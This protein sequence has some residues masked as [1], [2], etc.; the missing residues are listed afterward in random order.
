MKK[1]VSIFLGA[2]ILLTLVT[3]F[4]ISMQSKKTYAG[5]SDA[6]VHC[7]CCGHATVANAHNFGH[8]C[9]DNTVW[10]P[11]GTADE[12]LALATSSDVH[13]YLT[14]DIEL[15]S[16][17]EVPEAKLYICLNGHNITST[18]RVFF[19]EGTA[20]AC[21]N[22]R[23]YITDCQ[24]TPGTVSGSSK[25]NGG[26]LH[27]AAGRVYTYNGIFTSTGRETT[28]ATGG[29]FYFKGVSSSA[30]SWFYMLGGTIKDGVAVTGGNITFSSYAT[31]FFYDGEIMDG[32]ADTYGGNVNAGASVTVN[33]Y[34]T[35]IHGGT[36]STY[37]GNVVYS[38]TASM[39]GGK[40]YDGTASYG[41]NVDV[42]N[43]FT[44]T[45]GEIY[46]GTATDNYGGNVAIQADSTATMSAGKIYNGSAGTS[47]GNVAAYGGTF[48][49]SG[50]EIYGGTTG[51]TS[52]NKGGN[53]WISSYTSS[54]K[55]KLAKGTISGGKIHDGS[56]YRGGNVMGEGDADTLVTITGGEIYNGSASN[57]GGNMSFAACT[58]EFRG[59]SVYDG[60]RDGSKTYKTSNLYASSA[61][62]TYRF[63]GGEIAGH[64][65]FP[66]NCKDLTFGGSFKC[67]SGN[68]GVTIE[69]T[70]TDSKN[71]LIYFNKFNDD[72][73]ILIEKF[74][75][76]GNKNWV[77]S[78]DPTFLGT[79]E[80][81]FTASDLKHVN[82]NEGTITLESD[83]TLHI[84]ADRVG[85]IC[86]GNLE[87]GKTYGTGANAVTHHCT[88]VTWTKWTATD[89]LPTVATVGEVPGTYY[90]YLTKNVTLAS[91]WNPANTA[92][93]MVADFDGYHFVIDFNGHTVQMS[94]TSRFMTNLLSSVYAQN[95]H[96]SFTDSGNGGGVTM[97]KN[98]THTTNAGSLF[99]LNSKTAGYKVDIYG[100]IYNGNGGT[101]TTAKGMINVGVS[102]GVLNMFG[103]T[104]ICETT[105][106]TTSN[107]T[108]AGINVTSGTFNMYGGTI[109]DG[110]GHKGGN[111]YV[112]GSSSVFNM[113][114]GE[115]TNGTVS[116]ME[117]GYSGGNVYVASSGTFN[118]YGGKITDGSAYM[119]GNITTTAKLNI[120]DGEITGGLAQSNGANVSFY[121]GCVG[122]M[123]GGY[124][125][126]A[127][128]ENTKSNI[129]VNGEL[130][131]NGGKLISMQAISGAVTFNGG[132][133][134]G[135]LTT[136]A[137]A[138]SFTINGGYF[139]GSLS[140]TK[141]THTISGGIFVSDP[142]ATIAT[143]PDGLKAVDTNVTKDGV[144]YYFAIGEA[145]SIQVTST[146]TKEGGVL[147]TGDGYTLATLTAPADVVKNLPFTLTAPVVS[148]YKFSGW[149]TDPAGDPVSTAAT[150]EC[151]GV[152]GDT[153]FVAYYEAN[154]G[155]GYTLT[156]QTAS[157][158]DFTYSV[159]LGQNKVTEGYTFETGDKVGVG[160]E[161]T[162]THAACDNFIGWF[163]A[164]EKLVSADFEYKFRI[165]DDTLI[166]ARYT[167]STT[168]R[169]LML[170]DQNQVLADMNLSEMTTLKDLPVRIG[171]V[172]EGWAYN[173]KTYEA[174]ADGLNE[175]RTDLA[176]AGISEGIVQLKATYTYSE[177]LFTIR[178]Q[179]A[180]VEDG[181][182]MDGWKLSGTSE[183]LTE[184]ARPSQEFTV[185]TETKKI[186][187]YKFIGYTLV[188]A[189]TLISRNETLKFKPTKDTV[190]YAVYAANVG[191]T[192]PTINWSGLTVTEQTTAGRYTYSVTALR[193]VPAPFVM[194]EHGV[195]ITT[196]AMGIND[197]TEAMNVLTVDATGAV[198]SISKATDTTGTYTMNVKN[199]MTDATAY[200]R[201]YVIYLDNMGNRGVAYTDVA[202]GTGEGPIETTAPVD[203]F[204]DA[205]FNG[206]ILETPVGVTVT[207]LKGFVDSGT[208]SP[209]QATETV[210][211]NGKRRTYFEA[212][213]AGNYT[214]VAK[215]TG[216]Y[217][218]R[219]QLVM[220]AAEAAS[221]YVVDA[222]PGLRLGVP[223][224]A[225][226]VKR[227]N[228][229]V[230]NGFLSQ[231]TSR[232][233]DYQ[234]AFET[235][236]FQRDSY[237]Y[238]KNSTTT[239]AEML[240]F[241][242]SLEDGVHF[243][244]YSFGTSPVHNLDSQL[245]VLTTSDL[246][247]A[248]TYEEAA[249]IVRANGKLN[250]QIVTGMH[251]S[252][253][254]S[255]EAGLA[256]AKMLTTAA[257]E[258][259]L[260]KMNVIFVP[261]LNPDGS[262]EYTRENIANGF[263]MNRDQLSSVAVEVTDA[264]RVFR[265]FMAEAVLDLHEYTYTFTSTGNGVY[266]EV[267][268]GIG[269]VYSETD[270]RDYAWNATLAGFSE[271]YDNGISGKYYP[272]EGST[273]INGA[274]VRTGRGYYAEYGGISFLIESC[275]I[276]G[277]F[278]TYPMR[279]VGHCIMT[280]AIFDYFLEN[281]ELKTM[282]SDFRDDIIEN[283]GTYDPNRMIQLDTEPSGTAAGTHKAHQVNFSTGIY[284]G[285][286]SNISDYLLDKIL[287]ER[288]MPTA[289][290]MP[291][292]A[293]GIN[294]VLALM[295][296]HGIRY[297]ETTGA[298]TIALKQYKKLSA[299]SAELTAEKNVTFANGAYVFE[300]NQEGAHILAMLMEPDAENSGNSTLAM[301]GLVSADGDNLYPIY[302]YE[303]NLTDKTWN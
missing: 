53:I 109:R 130:T 14:A 269:N 93:S 68:Y 85:C 26:T 208:D 65:A 97:K 139:A 280:Q 29:V 233:P 252:E 5:G 21:D 119:G 158:S 296:K 84:S 66:Y 197:V 112:T 160:C 295:D 231:D 198:R 287:L 132:T 124:I 135:S 234:Y 239:H 172:A 150:Y 191:E 194:L 104:I 276:G 153:L 173:G 34:E 111:V 203:A 264:H 199:I 67:H 37:G 6:H 232:W 152:S 213:A 275:G 125:G 131:V 118:M 136:Y 2:V 223:G 180:T 218:A 3:V 13:A 270:M 79:A 142:A 178:L 31:A 211:K 141:G 9:N 230:E 87:D 168:V 100:G 145:V 244:T 154:E 277:D 7:L 15:T 147:K 44:M 52:S 289:Y 272:Y 255:A 242:H 271:L 78:S 144:T 159:L 209:I 274:K 216:Y 229:K 249:A 204:D 92:T 250:V 61:D 206:L 45:G 122:T 89:A 77:G 300:M 170:S 210:V 133:V 285:T 99:W 176:Q 268:S 42:R 25:S 186:S 62:G 33:H 261:R 8:K 91:S 293:A 167:D 161:I 38:G 20:S 102:D 291:K 23:L 298:A 149:Y 187:Q 292:D 88:D 43:T 253:P 58:L 106:D 177:E 46:N 49:M 74:D 279:V 120:Y 282:V 171:K 169:I 243:K 47:G 54:G 76:S 24:D 200:L 103:G 262:Y 69:N 247:A 224:E 60:K 107:S 128:A 157:P 117:S 214:Y 48:N 51:T 294:D 301:L 57:Q 63:T 35:A 189:G 28:D 80:E 278:T 215:G 41:G 260:D 166:Y 56:A 185:E 241:I 127:A 140:F 113:Y 237:E 184:E 126:A 73:D 251:G 202:Y 281:P 225:S 40:V 12:F 302:R 121:T 236:Y 188:E 90:F 196:S 98:A 195:L 108:N 175:L 86:G 96:V 219:T 266:T 165:G 70:S 212:L 226:S 39:S 146:G 290:V 248:D 30:K 217:T 162:L 138:C 179:K 228:E 258:K 227:Y 16:A 18:D 4:G 151:E 163:N 190:V 297:Y 207:L 137:D 205:D 134:T 94:T 36:A 123:D 11:I 238:G 55:M 116:V 81:G 72:A 245:M 82:V 256:F 1:K 286:T 273:A 192:E 156:V 164:A 193:D 105:N 235:P 254:A 174:T 129:G 101:N 27:C 71:Q 284:T 240:A 259:Y 17:L 201:G 115:I 32:T 288:T 95:V 181:D 182:T 59:G 263:D 10:T 283:G 221:Q 83:N 222:N 19:M 183:V 64:I 155:A 114:D 246:S 265:A 22:R 110:V 220:T 299:T 303:K 267:L 75:H 257:G 50:G 148:G 143:I